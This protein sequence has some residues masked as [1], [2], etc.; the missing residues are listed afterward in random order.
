MNE[1]V[2]GYAKGV[3][4]KLNLFVLLQVIWLVEFY[5][6]AA[7]S[8]KTFLENVFKINIDLPVVLSKY[9]DMIFKWMAEYN[10][11]LFVLAIIMFI[12]GLSGSCFMNISVLKKYKMIYQY[13]DFGI[14]AGAWMFFIFM[15]Y[16]LYIDLNG[17][18]LVVPL[19]ALI[20]CAVIKEI[21]EALE[22][23]GIEFS[24]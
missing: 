20:I 11:F 23:K 21:K 13:S 24:K 5:M 8:A 16:R 3:I 1:V 7:F 12:T 14:Y 18:F 19:V 17:W 9:S 10:Q 4:E 22:S 2:K 15:T 6:L